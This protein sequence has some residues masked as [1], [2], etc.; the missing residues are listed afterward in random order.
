MKKLILL[1]V[2]ALSSTIHAQAEPC[3]TIEVITSSLS[4]T[5]YNESVCLK[6]DDF[7]IHNSVNFNNWEYLSFD[8]VI[9]VRPVINMNSFSRIIYTN[10]NVNF[11]RLHM[12]G[13]DTIYVKGYLSIEDGVSNNSIEG[14]RNVIYSDEDV[15]YD[16]DYYSPG[17]T[18]FTS[19]GSYNNI[20]ILPIPEPMS[21][22]IT[23]IYLKG[24]TLHWSTPHPVEVD[25]LFS[26]NGKDF[27]KLLTTEESIYT[28]SRTGFYTV[29]INGKNSKVFYI[30]INNVKYKTFSMQGVEVDER[31]SPAG[32]YIRK[33]E[34]GITEKIFK[35]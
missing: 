10:N 15:L 20:L 29:G 1:T 21:I 19:G 32:V 5:T 24:N 22:S 7:I 26:N 8:G 16:G 11:R 25:I 9:D 35:L 31:Y 17:D 18:I 12:N 2:L 30:N 28:A 13:G 6:G 27:T 14:K 34:N 4:H 23:N 3:D 33:Y